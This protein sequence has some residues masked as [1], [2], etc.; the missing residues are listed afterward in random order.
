[1]NRSVNT[2]LWRSGL[3]AAAAYLLWSSPATAANVSWTLPAGQAGDW[4]IASNW[5][6][7]TVPTSTSNGYILNGGTTTVTFIG[8]TCD[9]LSLGGSGGTGTVQM[10]SGGLSTV[11]SQYVGFSGMGTFAQSGGTNNLGNGALYLGYGTSANGVYDLGGSGILCGS[12][13]LWGR[14]TYVGYDGTGTFTQSGGTN[15]TS[16]YVGK[17]AGSSGVYNLSGSGLLL[18]GFYGETVGVFGSGT[19]NQSGGTNINNQGLTIGHLANSTGVYIFISGL[20]SVGGGGEA[21]GDSGNVT[22]PAVGMVIQSGGTNSVPPGIFLGVNTGSIGS[23][24]LSGSGVVSTLYEHIG[25]S[26]TG[27]F[28]QSGGVNSAGNLRL[29]E[30]S[31]GSGTYNFDGGL[32]AVASIS[33]GPAS[34]AFNFNGGTLQASSGFS[35]SLPMTLGTSGGGATFDTAESVVTLS[36]S[37]SGPGSLSKIG[38]GT[39]VLGG[40]NTYAGPTTISQGTLLATNTAGSALGSGTVS[41]AAGAHLGGSGTISGLVSNFGDIAPGSDAATDTLHLY[42]GLTLNDGDSITLTLGSLASSDMLDLGP[43]GILTANGLTS[44]IFNDAGIPDDGGTYPLIEYAGFYGS[45]SNFSYPSTIG[46]HAVSL[47]DSGTAISLQVSAVPEPSTLAL[48]GAGATGLAV[49]SL[50][51]QKPKRSPSYAEEP[52]FSGGEEPVSQDG[53]PAILTLPSRWMEAARRAA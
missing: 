27:V 37:L 8:A 42:G 4:S 49:Y 41:V 25:L 12:G 13:P 51:R 38:T 32:L 53:G 46:Q 20:L 6:G 31:R 34:G 26:G 44:L 11:N 47:V 3:A 50:R 5:S 30:D 7:G 10:A 39:L 36:G 35:T 16:L 28:T 9:T 40:S 14:S 33:Q 24:N 18:A 21:I 48:L 19:L 52:T 43:G 29:G 1:M 17:D 15:N 23:Y 22:S 45:L 2:S